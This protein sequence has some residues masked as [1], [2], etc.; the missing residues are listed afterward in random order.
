MTTDDQA[1]PTAVLYA[2]KST[3]DERGSIPT[4]LQDARQLSER[5]GWTVV[6]EHRGTAAGI[7]R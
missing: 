3:T 6:A 5:E 2:A 4:Q 7:V 1:Q